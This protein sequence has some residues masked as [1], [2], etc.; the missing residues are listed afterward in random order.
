MDL[1]RADNF[2]Y[3]FYFYF[4]SFYVISFA[5]LVRFKIASICLEGVL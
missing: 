1:F 5:R 3:D 4:F 2:P